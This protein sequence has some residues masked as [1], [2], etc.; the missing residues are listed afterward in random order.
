MMPARTACTFYVPLRLAPISVISRHRWS[1]LLPEVRHTREYWGIPVLSGVPE[2]THQLLRVTWRPV[3]R[4][5]QP[6]L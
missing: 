1:R 4:T 3:T 5:S 2:F 6:Y